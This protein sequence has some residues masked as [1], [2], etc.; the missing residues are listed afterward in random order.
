MKQLISEI[1]AQNLNTI[2]SFLTIKNK[3]PLVTRLPK[4]V[5]NTSKDHGTL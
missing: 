1:L 5:L 4:G 3:I 2:N